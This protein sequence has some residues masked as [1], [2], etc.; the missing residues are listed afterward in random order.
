MENTEESGD[1][2]NKIARKP[3][4]PPPRRELPFP[5]RKVSRGAENMG[6]QQG[7]KSETAEAMDEDEDPGGEETSDDEL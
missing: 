2:D 7:T 5:S 1:G 6:Q 3:S 4:P